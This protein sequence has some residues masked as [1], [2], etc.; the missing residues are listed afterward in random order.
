[1]SNLLI[2]LLYHFLFYFNWKQQCFSHFCINFLSKASPLLNTTYQLHS[3]K[4]RVEILVLLL[5]GAE[6]NPDV[7]PRFPRF[8]WLHILFYMNIYCVLQQQHM[9]L[10]ERVSAKPL[11]SADWSIWLQHIIHREIKDVCSSPFTQHTSTVRATK[12]HLKTE[13][14][15]L[16]LCSKLFLWFHEKKLWHR[17][18]VSLWTDVAPEFTDENWRHTKV[19]AL[20]CGRPHGKL[21][22]HRSKYA[23]IFDITKKKKTL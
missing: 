8:I 6:T 11:S 2:Y 21:H 15:F 14:N 22:H 12:S 19:V 1:M 17:L 16:V 23:R 9:E 4:F 10:W 20:L 7:S 3:P 18:Q 13:R 5:R